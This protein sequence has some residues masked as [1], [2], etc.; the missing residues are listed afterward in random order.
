MEREKKT[1]FHSIHGICSEILKMKRTTALWIHLALPAAAVLLFSLYYSRM[2]IWDSLTK[3]SAF[4]Q[5]AG[6]VYPFVIGVV[7]SGS[8]QLEENVGM[9]F[10][11]GTGSH[12]TTGLLVKLGTL[13][14]LSL[15]SAALAVVGFGAVF[16]GILKQDVL[17]IPF[18]FRACGVLFLSVAVLYLFH[19][20]LSLQFSKAASIGAGIA[21]SLVSALLLT[22]LGE[23]I[24]Y[25]IPCA[26]AV[27][28]AEYT[29]R[30]GADKALGQEM[31]ELVIRE[32]E[33]GAVCMAV[34]TAVAFLLF[35][36]WFHHY[37]GRKGIE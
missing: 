32:L 18:Y 35:L 13:L 8:I 2:Q 4:L 28:F 11:S 29:V 24:W 27:R 6:I 7:C 26:W 21:E 10:L 19:L 31:K 5:A 25:Y 37:E 20:F 17:G 9:Q 23:E 36:L 22:G 33:R 1:G 34:M 12:K 30:L 16:G 14:L 15:L 3:A